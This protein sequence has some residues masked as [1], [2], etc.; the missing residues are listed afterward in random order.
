MD[1]DTVLKIINEL[2]KDYCIKYEEL[3][4]INIL[5][6]YVP[7]ENELLHELIIRKYVCVEELIK[8]IKEI[9]YIFEGMSL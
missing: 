5:I 7:A 2:F 6:E 3:E 9:R 8:I 4:R 1:L